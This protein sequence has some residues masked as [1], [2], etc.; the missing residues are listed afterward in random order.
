MKKAIAVIILGLLV[1]PIVSPVINCCIAESV[2]PPGRA[3]LLTGGW[4]EQRDGLT[5]LHVSG[6]HYQM[7]FQHGTL[8]REQVQED[9]RAFL[10]FANQSI[11]YDTLLG[12]WNRE[13]P[14]VPQDYKDELQ[15]M[16]DGANISYTNVM[17][18]ITAIEY[19]DHGCFGISAWGNATENGTLYHS[20]SFDLPSVIKDPITGKHPY[21]NSI[22][23]VRNP[24]N[25]SASLAPSIAGSFH[26]GGGINENG[27]ALGIQIC[28]SKDQTFEGNPYQF[29]VQA[30]LDH[31]TTAQ[32]AIDILN[33]NRTHGFN[34][35]ISQ[36]SPAKGFALEQTANHTYVGTYNDAT[37]SRSP[38]YEIDHVVRRTNVFLDPTIARTQR[39]L[40]DPSG[41]FG[42]LALLLHKWTNKPFFAVY[43]L[44]DSVSKE[45]VAGNSTLDLNTTMAALQNGYRSPDDAILRLI[46]ILGKGTGMTE[47]WNQWTA[48]PA[49]GDMVVSFA[50]STTMAYDTQVY[51]VNFYA[52]LHESPP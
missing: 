22:L 14:Y 26:T 1:L 18:A 4:V 33:T 5:I 47:S 35:V 51:F 36:A 52:L 31:A 28:W 46:K 44:Y 38:F 17:V 13:S 48:C 11:S 10:D 45:L 42:F 27:I 41:F 29:R 50:N 21:E 32:E 9:I 19:A 30:V 37:E 20:R 15:G 7:G 25:G 3:S 40:Y 8:L 16:A 24:D 39:N 12:M 49:N 34:F 6:S 43:H 2:R 23:V